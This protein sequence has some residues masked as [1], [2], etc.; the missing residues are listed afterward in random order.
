M[1]V[2]EFESQTAGIFVVA[3]MVLVSV[4]SFQNCWR[5]GYVSIEQFAVRGRYLWVWHLQ[6]FVKWKV[7]PPGIR[8]RWAFPRWF[9]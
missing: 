4:P 1:A 8:L 6:V 2:A 3:S 7:L 5:K 9:V